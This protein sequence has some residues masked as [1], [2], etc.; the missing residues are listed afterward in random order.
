M[1]LNTDDVVRVGFCLCGEGDG[2]AEVWVDWCGCCGKVW[3]TGSLWRDD[4]SPPP[5]GLFTATFFDKFV[6]CCLVVAR[7]RGVT[8]GACR[9]AYS[10]NIPARTRWFPVDDGAEV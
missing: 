7:E 5:D 4:A 1:G 3:R 6:V 2:Y 10:L 9:E 8:L